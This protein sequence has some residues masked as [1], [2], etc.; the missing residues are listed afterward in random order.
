M[1]PEV[2][3]G[4]TGL[5]NQPEPRGFLDSDASVTPKAPPFDVPRGKGPL[6]SRQIS[7]NAQPK[8]NRATI[9]DEMHDDSIAFIASQ[10]KVLPDNIKKAIL[11]LIRVSVPDESSS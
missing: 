3:V 8:Q 1:F 11:T 7:S 6:N 9:C 5:D 10:W 4:D 2:L